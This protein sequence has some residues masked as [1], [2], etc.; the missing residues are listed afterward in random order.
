MI[1]SSNNSI[2]QLKKLNFYARCDGLWVGGGIV[3]KWKVVDSKYE[4][5][6]WLALLS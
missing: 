6:K 5:K 4:I 3:L 2:K 1:A